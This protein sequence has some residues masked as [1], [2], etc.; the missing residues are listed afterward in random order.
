M[1]D[2]R[3]VGT[4]IQVVKDVK[5][6]DLALEVVNGRVMVSSLQVAEH[7]G[8][9]HKNVIQAIER[10]EIPEEFNRLNFQ[11]VEYEDKKGEKRPAYLM[12]RDGF[13]LLVMGFTGPRA[14]EWKIKYIEAFNAMERML[15]EKVWED[16]QE[17]KQKESDERLE[18]VIMS[19]V[20]HWVEEKL[21]KVLNEIR[22]RIDVSYASRVFKVEERILPVRTFIFRDKPIRGMIV[23]EEFGL[24]GK[25]IAQLM[26]WNPTY[27]LDEREYLLKRGLSAGGGVKKWRYSLMCLEYGRSC[28]KDLGFGDIVYVTMVGINELK[29]LNKDL[30]GFICQEIMPC[31]PEMWEIY[32]RVI[33]K[34]V[35]VLERK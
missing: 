8:K 14:M 15:R 7:F 22:M 1:S 23:G 3:I 11:P 25:D 18:R 30:Y 16:V 21:N 19:R 2:L 33:R 32:R 5:V 27:S 12:T 26:G 35:S 29:H 4:G 24:C 10:L 13:T 31:L 20:E 17:R 9:R 34:N 6:G 28:H